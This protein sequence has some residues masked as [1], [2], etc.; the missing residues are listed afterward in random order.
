[1]IVGHPSEMELQRY[2]LDEPGCTAAMI[3]HI[4]QC[5]N[6]QAS[7]YAYRLV[8]AEM[9]RQSRPAFDFDVSALILAQLQTSTPVPARKDLFLYIL[10]FGAFGLIGLP[11]YFFRQDLSKMLM[12]MLP[13][14]IGLM[15][16]T[17][18]LILLFS[19]IEM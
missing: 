1:M 17:A 7:V 15:A 11:F 6:C 4:E 9:K 12:G 18:A 16:M 3:G 5:E 14:A 19:G 10:I 2:A 13:E 8:S